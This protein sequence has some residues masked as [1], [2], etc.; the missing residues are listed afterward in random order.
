MHQWMDAVIHRY[1]FLVLAQLAPCFT[2]VVGVK[3]HFT[4]P[5]KL[6]KCTVDFCVFVQPY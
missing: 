1:K 3:G 5:R 6:L 2:V 4:E